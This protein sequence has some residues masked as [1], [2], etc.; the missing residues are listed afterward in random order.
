MKKAQPKKGTQKKA[1]LPE[2]KAQAIPRMLPVLP[3]RDLV[4]FPHVMLSLHVTRE[5]GIKAVEHAVSKQQL[6][7]LVAQKNQETDAPL[8]KDLY[9]I[10]VVA[11][12]AKT[13]QLPDGRVKVLMHGLVRAQVVEYLPQK[14][15]LTARIKVL[16]TTPLKPDAQV[17]AVIH[18]IRQNLQTLVERDHLPE[19]MLLV[20][21]DLDD[22]GVLAD[23][24]IAHYKL[25]PDLS[26]AILEQ[27]DPSARLR[28][29]EEI[30]TKDLN[31]FLVSE[32]IRDRARDELSRGQQEYYLREQIRQIQRELGEPEGPVEDLA[33]LQR[34]LKEA[35]LPPHAELEAQRQF[36]RLERMSAES[37]EYALLRTYLEWIGDLPWS[38]VSNDQIDLRRAKRVLE[39]DHF[40][41][42]KVKRRILEFLSV[43]KL[44]SDSKGPILCFVGPPG[45]GKTSLG[46]SIATALGRKFHRISLGGVRDEAEIRGHRRTYVGALPGRILQGLKQAGTRNPVFLLDELDKVGADFRGDPSSALLEV[47]DP[48]QNK[49]FVDH[50]LNMS[51]DLSDVL[52]IATAN[53]LD[54][55]PAALLDRLEVI[56]ISGYT[57]AEKLRIAQRFLVP[58]QLL[59][60]GLKRRKIKFESSVLLQVIE[61]YTR[62]SGVRNLE[63]E[64]G[65][66]CRSVAFQLAKGTRNTPALN[67][68]FV[69]RVLGPSR[70]DIDPALGR[71]VIGL[72]QGLA[73]TIHGGEMMPVEAS[74]AKGTGV[75]TLTGQLG[76]VMQES[77]RAALF[78][79]RANAAELQLDPEFHAKFDFHV[80]VPAG[81][82]PKDGPSAGI[83][84]ASALISALSSRAVLKDFAM[85]GEMTLR[86]N[87]LAV[88][89][90]KEKALAA[91]QHGL[92]KVVIPADNM[93]DLDEI[94]KEQRRQLTFIPVKHISEVLQLVL[95]APLRPRRG[96]R[97]A[98]ATKKPT[99]EA[100]V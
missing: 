90:L 21:E 62:E 10:G 26:Q 37:S 14:S 80:H 55:I 88:G 45:V 86:G 12:I 25:Q 97:T 59:E 81:A 1:E 40:G 58:R 17:Q 39:L 29:A 27:L 84:I 96:S 82:T 42:E 28:M 48:Q 87:V 72:A 92:R 4:A 98:S 32:K 89:G 19:E 2:H 20:T 51:F 93:K 34:S 30:I 100:E 9:R 91:L 16:E 22:A 95:R 71:H 54:T 18:R 13:L 49:D 38:V 6:V 65:S 8:E 75:L 83:T 57:T 31:Q 35:K 11:S 33:L 94:P 24:I 76:S 15:H 85:T 79:A 67:S 56:S 3:A 44:K 43:R 41:L 73:W 69:E 23:V 60:N 68:A 46:R 7:L 64:I 36:R 63:R 61:R 50:Y 52:F 53:T 78:Y 77:A 70:Y 99:L 5:A 66:L 47:L 74:V